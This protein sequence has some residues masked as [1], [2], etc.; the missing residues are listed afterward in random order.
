MEAIRDQRLVEPEYED[1]RRR[2]RSVPFRISE[3]LRKT[4]EAIRE[5]VY[6]KAGSPVGDGEYV[7]LERETRK[8]STFKS[9][10]VKTRRF[11][12]EKSIRK[13]KTWFHRHYIK[14]RLFERLPWCDERF[15]E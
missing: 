1:E 2:I 5:N 13:D 3:N 4:E 12:S 9:Y 14:V 7:I 11:I 6:R 15:E 8:Y 10:E